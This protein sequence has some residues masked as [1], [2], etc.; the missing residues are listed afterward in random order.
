[1]THTEQLRRIKL[2]WKTIFAITILACGGLLGYTV[3]HM[4]DQ[5]ELPAEMVLPLLSVNQG[6]TTTKTLI[7]TFT[8]AR[9][10]SE[11]YLLETEARRLVSIEQAFDER[12]RRIDTQLTLLETTQ[13]RQL[14]II[15]ANLK[16]LKGAFQEESNTTFRLHRRALGLDS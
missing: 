2:I 16:R 12:L 7:N 10:L 1:M 9:S 4:G 8:E 15:V 6:E 13:D 5:P 14:E 11:D 3:S